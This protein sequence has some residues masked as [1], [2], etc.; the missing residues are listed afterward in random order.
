M[1]TVQNREASA[2]RRLTM[3][4]S[5]RNFNPCHVCCKEVVH[6]SEGP[7]WEVG[8]YCVYAFLHSN[9]PGEGPL[10]FYSIVGHVVLYRHSTTW[11]WTITTTSSIEVYHKVLCRLLPLF[12]HR[13]PCQSKYPCINGMSI[14]YS[15]IQRQIS[16]FTRV[17]GSPMHSSSCVR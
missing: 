1:S 10:G 14:Q 15:P 2:S 5:G 8:L 9:R 16:P 13:F 6:I 4:Y 3:Y 11:P 12:I 17:N 7:L